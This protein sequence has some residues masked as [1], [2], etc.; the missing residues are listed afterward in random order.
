VD[1]YSEVDDSVPGEASSLSAS[2]T[3]STNMSFWPPSA[4]FTKTLAGFKA[5]FDGSGSHEGAAQRSLTK[6]EWTFGDGTKKT[7]TGPSVTHTY[8][9]SPSTP[10]IYKVTLQV[11]DSGGAVSKPVVHPVDGTATRFGVTKTVSKI[12]VAGIV[13]PNR[14][15]HHVDVELERK[16]SGSFHVLAAHSASLNGTSHFATSFS[17]P[18]PGTCRIQARYPGDGTHLASQEVK[19]F[20]C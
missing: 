9:M 13:K 1:Y 6:W 14:S 10:P 12:D 15:G 4:A 5:H 20:A 3:A 11:V 2:A 18:P 19:T 7:T 16:Q 17:R 8:P